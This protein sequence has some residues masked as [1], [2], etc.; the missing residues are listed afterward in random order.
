M[1][2]QDCEVSRSYSAAEVVYMHT[3]LMDGGGGVCVCVQLVTYFEALD[4]LFCD[5]LKTEDLA[6]TA[7]FC[8]WFQLA[9]PEAGITQQSFSWGH[10]WAQRHS[11]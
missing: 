5:P 1:K 11:P 2:N 9:V 3:C 7:L 10:Y 8:A 6:D 4:I